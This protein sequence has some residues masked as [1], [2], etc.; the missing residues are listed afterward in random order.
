MTYITLKGKEALQV[1]LDEKMKRLK[2]LQQ[3]KAHAYSA[4]GDGWHDN[5][6]WTQLGQQE[7][8]L[9][10]EIGHLQKRITEAKI[11]EVFPNGIDQVQIGV[12]VTFI[13]TN[14]KSG[15]SNKNKFLIATDGEA[16]VKKGILSNSSPL[17][18]ALL[19]MKI[20]ETKLITFPAGDFEISV[21]AIEL[22]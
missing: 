22:E 15:K 19:G 18:E 20:N 7:E 4:S 2:E 14:K 13:Q 1:K 11:I 5:P 16:D 3:E 17:G 10:T 6:G 9:S 21:T 8:M 12:W